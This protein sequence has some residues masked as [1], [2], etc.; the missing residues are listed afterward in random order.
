MILLLEDEQNLN[1]GIS[2][3][4]TKEGYEV[5][6]CLTITDAKEKWQ[7]HREQIELII[8]DLSLPDGNGLDFCQAVRSE[9]NVLIMMLTSYNQE[10]DI[11]SGY[12]HGADEYVTKPFSLMVLVLKVKALLK[13]SQ[14]EASQI[15]RSG[16]LNFHLTKMAV[17]IGEEQVFLSKTELQVL[18]LFLEHPKQILSQEQLLA[19]V[20]DEKGDYVDANTVFEQ[21]EM[22]LGLFFL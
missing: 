21:F 11:V 10:Y 4:L 6:P 7:A 15:L 3:C 16:E 13:R 17:F 18:R 5:L 9:S 8:S 1:H 2:L 22:L 14:K 20:W 12:D 19:R